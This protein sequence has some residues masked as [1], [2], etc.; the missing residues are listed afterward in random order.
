V[1]NLCGSSGRQR[2]MGRKLEGKINILK[3]KIDF[4]LSTN[5]KLSRQI[6]GSINI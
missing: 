1:G 5:F 6:K 2:A 3:E 4:P